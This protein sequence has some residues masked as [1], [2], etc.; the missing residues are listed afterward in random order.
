M[1][2]VEISQHGGPEVLKIAE[3]PKP[4][5]QAGQVL[6]KV[7]AAGLIVLMCCNAQVFIH[8]LLML[9]TCRSRNS[10]RDCRR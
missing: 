8:R 5:L 9:L 6:I 3:R 2:V 4:V 7:H 1:K 10:G